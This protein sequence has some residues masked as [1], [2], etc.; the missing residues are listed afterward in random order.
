MFVRKFLSGHVSDQLVKYV[1]AR[2][3][4]RW[5]GYYN[6]YLFVFIMIAV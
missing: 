1:G 5:Y 4:A 3:L 6:Y 2:L